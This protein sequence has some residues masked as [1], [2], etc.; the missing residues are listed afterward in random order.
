[1][2]I[3]KYVTYTH[4]R[5]CKKYVYGTWTKVAELGLVV[6]DSLFGLK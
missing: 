4:I 6:D 3:S 2:R 5:V 1:M